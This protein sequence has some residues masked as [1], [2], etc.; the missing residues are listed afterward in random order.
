[1]VMCNIQG[2][3]LKLQTAVSFSS[4]ELFSMFETVLVVLPATLLFGSSSLLIDI[5]F[6]NLGD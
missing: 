6:S 4:S 2:G 1:M 5:D 3:D